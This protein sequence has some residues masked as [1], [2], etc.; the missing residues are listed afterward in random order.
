MNSI[1]N[2]ESSSFDKQ[3]LVPKAFK[4]RIKKKLAYYGKTM[5]IFTKYIM[6]IEVLTNNITI[7]TGTKK[8][9]HHQGFTTDVYRH[10]DKKSGKMKS[11]GSWQFCLDECTL[12]SSC[13]TSKCSGSGL[14]CANCCGREG[15]MGIACG[16]ISTI[17][18][19]LC[20]RRSASGHLVRTRY[21]HHPISVHLHDSDERIA[22]RRQRIAERFYPVTIIIRG[23]FK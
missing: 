15:R 2:N 16:H 3:K 23:S 10:Y 9:K 8:K 17:T 12:Y 7:R 4:I 11:V 1:M 5:L 19:R 22:F 14:T 21:C 6:I 18:V 13:G 20:N